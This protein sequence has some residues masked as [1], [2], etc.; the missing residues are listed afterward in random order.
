MQQT[1]AAIEEYRKANYDSIVAN[2][3]RKVSLHAMQHQAHE[4]VCQVRHE[5]VTLLLQRGRSKASA[6]VTEKE[7]APP[8]SSSNLLAPGPR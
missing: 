5:H 7:T 1:E 6:S 4:R 3:A 2:D 8:D